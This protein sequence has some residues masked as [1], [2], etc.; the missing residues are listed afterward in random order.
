MLLSPYDVRQGNFGGLLI[1][2]VTKSGTNEL[3]G[4]GFYYTQPHATVA[5][6]SNGLEAP[7][8]SKKQYGGSAGGPI[9]RDHL[10]FFMSYDQQKQSQGIPVNSTL[11]DPEIAARYPTLASDPTYVQTQDGRVM[12]VL[13]SGD[14]TIIGTSYLT[15]NFNA[16]LSESNGVQHYKQQKQLQMLTH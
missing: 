13:P 1:N 16:Y 14:F 4:S 7:D 3:H 9:M 2:A 12:F 8:Q 15:I 5:K 10:F 11:L 6:L